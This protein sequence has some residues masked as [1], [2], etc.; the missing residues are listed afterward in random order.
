MRIRTIVTCLTI[1]VLM[2]SIAMSQVYFAKESFDY[3]LGTPIDTLM[4]A[5]S[6][7]WGGG[8]YKIVT[9]QLNAMVA[10]DTG[11]PY[12]DMNY[13]VSHAGNHLESIP[14]PTGTELRYG[15]LLDKVWPDEAG[16]TY[17]VSLIMDVKNATDN[18]T[19]VGLKLFTGADGELEM[20]GKG[21]GLDKYTIGSGWHGSE[22]PEVSTVSWDTGPVWLVGEIVMSGDAGNDPTYMWISPDPAG[23]VPDTSL[24]DAVC[25]RGINEGF[26]RIRVEFGGTVGDGLQVSFDEI[27][28]GTSWGDVSSFLPTTG[29]TWRHNELPNQFALS[30]NYPNPF[31]PST[32]I[33]YTLKG[34]GKVRLAVYNL[35]GREAAVLVDG[36]QNAG[37]YIVNFN[38]VGWSSGIYFY[39]LQTANEVITRKMTLLK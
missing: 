33:H 38:A 31:N 5:A 11:L 19:W 16:R 36:V 21:H 27:R 26:D 17:W 24:A 1:I 37:E 28:L 13:S 3:P 32:T 39:R 23:P 29:I 4:G 9:S 14:D 12:D 25:I 34:N 7:G 6:N 20:F 22:G 30:Q 2:S 18:A 10:A 8:W 15:R 35:M